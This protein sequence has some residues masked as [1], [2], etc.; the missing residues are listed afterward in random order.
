MRRAIFP[1]SI[2]TDCV[3]EVAQDAD[4]KSRPPRAKLA[5]LWKQTCRARVFIGTPI[6][7]FLIPM[8]ALN[9]LMRETVANCEPFAVQC[10]RDPVHD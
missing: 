9:R 2:T 6:L 8:G 5:T 1:R 10:V 3:V 4:I 7:R